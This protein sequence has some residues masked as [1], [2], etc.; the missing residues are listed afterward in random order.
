LVKPRK[1]KL[2][3]KANWDNEVTINFIDVVKQ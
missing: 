1:E 3:I 2:T